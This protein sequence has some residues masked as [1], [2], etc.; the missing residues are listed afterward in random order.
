MQN[1]SLS[2]ALKRSVAKEKTV[3]NQPI[4][5]EW[6]CPHCGTL[7]GVERGGKLHLRY[8]TSRFVI[9]GHVLA[10]CRRCSEFCELTI[11][12]QANAAE[13]LSSTGRIA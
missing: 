10:V 6:R 12:A 11:G 3:E 4:E 13:T 9:T 1:L 5:T 8:K 2:A 7:H